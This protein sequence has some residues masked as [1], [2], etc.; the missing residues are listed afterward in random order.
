[1]ITN[2]PINQPTNPS[3]NVLLFADMDKLLG[4]SEIFMEID[5]LW[6]TKS[7]DNPSD[8]MNC[9]IPV[10]LNREGN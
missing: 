5:I 4:E 10:F 3:M 1:M 7:A 6:M 9:V 2:Q 8:D